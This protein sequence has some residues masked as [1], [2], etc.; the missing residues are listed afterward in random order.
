M[1][2]FIKITDGEKSTLI[3]T[4]RIN[5]LYCDA[6]KCNM[7]VSYDESHSCSKKQNPNCYRL[8]TAFMNSI[9]EFKLNDKAQI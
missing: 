9:A 8:M 4:D 1:S 6:T 5:I 2:K 7:G 3:N